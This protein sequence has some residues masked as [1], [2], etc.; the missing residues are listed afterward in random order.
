MF[1]CLS[2][3]SYL[4]RYGCSISL[5]IPHSMHLMVPTRPYFY[6]ML[7]HPN[8]TF[9]PKEHEQESYNRFSL[10]PPPDHTLLPLTHDPPPP[11]L[12]GYRLVKSRPCACSTPLCVQNLPVVF[13]MVWRL[14]CTS[15]RPSLTSYGVSCF[16]ISLSLWSAPLKG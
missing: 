9:P 1:V 8:R 3:H 11:I 4:L 16:L 10:S 13:A 15:Y 2:W 5:S 12:T 6:W 7:C 14:L